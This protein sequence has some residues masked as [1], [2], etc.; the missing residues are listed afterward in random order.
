MTILHVLLYDKNNENTNNMSNIYLS[1]LEILSKKYNYDLNL[2]SIVIKS[3][4]TLPFK[5]LQ[6]SSYD[7]FLVASTVVQ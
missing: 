5:Y 3:V 7:R 4:Q 1:Q 6:V 2:A